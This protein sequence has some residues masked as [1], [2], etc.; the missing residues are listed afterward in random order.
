[1]ANVVKYYNE[2]TDIVVKKMFNSKITK[3]QNLIAKQVEF[4]PMSKNHYLYLNHPSKE[5]IS[6]IA[7]GFGKNGRVSTI[8]VR[9]AQGKWSH[10]VSPEEFKQTQN[11]KLQFYERPKLNFDYEG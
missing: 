10:A 4:G 11:S 6:A 9:D 1:M 8:R 5:P 7:T 3:R 2:F